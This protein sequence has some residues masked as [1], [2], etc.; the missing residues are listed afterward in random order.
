[1]TFP[2]PLTGCGDDPLT[3][4]RVEINKNGDVA[5]ALT[6]AAANVSYDL[7]LGGANA[8]SQ[9]A[10]AVLATDAA[11]NG[12]FR[13]ASVFDMGQ[14]GIVA[15]TLSRNGSVEFVAGFRGE[16]EL[17]AGLVACGAINTPA[18][19]ASCG[20]D[21]LRSGKAEVEEG[22]VKVELRRLNAVRGLGADGGDRVL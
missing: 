4:G 13:G 18:A 12:A 9:L 20:S 17:E 16:H 6:G 15:L 8:S 21:A 5:A 7:V 22:D 11:G 1:M 10:I 3:R 19:L 14:A 2:A